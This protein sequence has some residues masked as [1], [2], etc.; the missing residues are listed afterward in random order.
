MKALRLPV[1]ENINFEVDLLCYYVLTCDPWGP[2]PFG[3][4]GHHIKKCDKGPLLDATC[5]ISKLLTF[6][7]QRRKILK[8]TF[9]VPMFQFVTARAGQV[10]IPQAS[11]EQSS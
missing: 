5:Q 7:L 11:Y 8:M 6:Q 4:Q 10:L 3:P 2:Q 1:S 9:F